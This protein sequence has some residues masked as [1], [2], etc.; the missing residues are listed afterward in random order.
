MDLASA[1]G[2]A[3]RSM[4]FT[5]AAKGVGPTNDVWKLYSAC[6]DVVND[7]C[8]NEMLS[9]WVGRLGGAEAFMSSQC[10]TMSEAMRIYIAVVT[11]TQQE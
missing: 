2:K 10:W 6:L 11:I 4:S 7:E 1:A 8:T 3:N 9:K 5:D